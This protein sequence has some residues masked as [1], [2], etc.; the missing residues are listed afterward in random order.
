MGVMKLNFPPGLGHLTD[1]CDNNFHSE[2]KNRYYNIISGLNL[3][4][5]GFKDKCESIHSAYFNG[6]EDSI[7]NY[8]FRCG[9]LGDEDP[10]EIGRRLLSEGFYPSSKFT[11]VHDRQLREYNNWKLDSDSDS[12]SSL[13]L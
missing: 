8:F 10:K 1:P 3:S 6:K 9:I 12:D 11:E 13:S 4:E 2:D 7:I 5:L